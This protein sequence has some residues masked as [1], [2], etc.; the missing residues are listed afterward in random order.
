MV[1][2]ATVKRS[3]EAINNRCLRSQ[4]KINFTVERREFKSQQMKLG[5]SKKINYD[6][7]YCYCSRNKAD[8]MIVGSL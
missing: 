7:N 2:A 6:L 4:R 5:E 3:L 1:A 8:E